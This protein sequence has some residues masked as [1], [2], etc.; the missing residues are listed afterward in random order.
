M[1]AP[2]HIV[3]LEAMDEKLDK[4]EAQNAAIMHALK[5]KKKGI[6]FVSHHANMSMLFKP[7]NPNFKRKKWGLQGVYI[8]L[9]YFCSNTF[10]VGICYNRVNVYPQCMF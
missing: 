5:K 2:A 7:L 6:I 3:T 8:F 9:S 10:I 4:I 1:E